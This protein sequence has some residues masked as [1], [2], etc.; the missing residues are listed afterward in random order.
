LVVSIGGTPHLN[1]GDKMRTIT[2]LQQSAINPTGMYLEVP[3]I[4]QEEIDNAV[5][6][7]AKL[8]SNT[9]SKWLV[10]YFY[11]EGSNIPYASQQLVIYHNR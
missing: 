10:I 5:L 8:C 4:T 1:Q 6:N 11:K 2:Q 7:G 9:T 3:D